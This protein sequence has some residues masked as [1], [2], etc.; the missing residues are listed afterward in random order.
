MRHYNQDVT[1]E[2]LIFDVGAGMSGKELIRLL[3][4]TGW[5]EDRI[6]GSHHILKKD[7][8]LVSVPVHG[9]EDLPLGTLKQILQYTGLK[10][11]LDR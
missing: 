7:G 1:E 9:H 4:K 6:K 5:K 11:N 8:K 2:S 10:L 3:K